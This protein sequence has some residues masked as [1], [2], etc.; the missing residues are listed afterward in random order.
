MTSEAVRR[1]YEG[2]LR[3]YGDIAPSERD[4][5][6]RHSVTDDVVSINPEGESRGISALI[7]HIEAFQKQKPGAY[8]TSNKLI[9]HHEQFLSEWT[10]FSKE[11]SSVATAHTYGRFS[12]QG[13]I[14][15]L[16]GFFDPQ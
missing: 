13:L 12:Q 1:T 2:Y 15:Y 11:G 8:F 4:R 6:L 9:I 10:M 7:K 16:I 5:L 14:T 3:A